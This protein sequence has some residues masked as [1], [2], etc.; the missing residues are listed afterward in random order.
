M[1]NPRRVTISASRDLA[2]AW[3]REVARTVRVE[4]DVVGEARIVQRLGDTLGGPALAALERALAAGD[5]DWQAVESGYRHDVAGGY[6]VYRPDDQSL[7]IVAV[8]SDRVEGA[9]SASEI[10]HGEVRATITA[11]AEGHYY[12]DGWGGHTAARAEETARQA[13]QARLDEEAR[14]RLEEASLQA[15]AGV[16][17]AVEAQAAERAR[18]ALEETSRQRREALEGQAREHL[19]TV[20]L[21]ARQAF[22]SM[23]GRAYRDAI[24]AY[25]RRHG[26]EVVADR[27]AGGVIEIELNL[28]R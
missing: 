13:A 19:E 1:C 4:A 26:A 12:D 8:R 14:G 15:E 18:Q 2:E 25:A 16:Q 17:G 10:L 5:P 9:G 22:H 24:L 28:S 23:L 7:E 3:Q 20:G 21:R 6:V 11:E 27:Q